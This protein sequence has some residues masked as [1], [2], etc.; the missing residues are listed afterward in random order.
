M[1]ITKRPLIAPPK[2]QDIEKFIQSAPDGEKLKEGKEDDKGSEQITLR[3]AKDQLARLT[4]MAEKQGIPR[5]SYIKR[6][7]ALQLAQDEKNL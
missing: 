5:A 2:E 1:A 6:A 3:I 7:I 4:E